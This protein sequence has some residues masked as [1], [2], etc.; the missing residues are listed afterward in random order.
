M[1]KRMSGSVISLLFGTQSAFTMLVPLVG[2]LIAD[3]WGL[4][5][6]FLMLTVTVMI[7]A[8]MALMVPA[9]REAADASA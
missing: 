5:A 3:Q 2:G 4:A 8:V 1:A 9:P 7:A 6:T